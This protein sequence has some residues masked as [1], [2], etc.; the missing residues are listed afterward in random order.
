MGRSHPPKEFTVQ[1]VSAS[2]V[3]ASTPAP[4]HCGVL[5]ET[6]YLEQAQPR[7]L[8]D[9]LAAAGHRVSVLDTAA[10]ALSVDDAGWLSGLDVVVARG[11]SPELLAR[12]AVA[13]TF[14]VPTPNR[15]RAIAAVLDKAH[16]ATVL[17]AAGIPTP[18]T[19]IG[20]IAQL[21][22]QIPHS[23]YPL[24]V[25]PVYGDNGRDIRIVATPRALAE[26]PWSEPCAIAQRYIDNDGFDVKLYV[27]GMRVWAM[28]KLSPLHA[29][30]AP[31]AP[32]SVPPAWRELALRCG[33]AFGLQLYGVDCIE[34]DGALQVIEVNDFP[35]YSGVPNAGALLATHLLQQAP[36]R[37][38]A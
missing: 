3:F 5:A 35:N 36:A 24:V 31:A 30:S 23:E 6:R 16:M 21:S 25:K 14:G 15:R 34:S 27:I 8:I 38:Y 4:L 33:Q 20:G 1:N 7:G 18:S 28:R 17:R 12:L 19:W 9:A 37:R 29:G 10:G 32:L 22:R 26:L 2:R 11:R 13:E